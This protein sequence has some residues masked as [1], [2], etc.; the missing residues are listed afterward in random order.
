MKSALSALEPFRAQ[1]RRQQVD[2]QQHR[3]EAGQD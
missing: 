3:Y 2:E 1:Q